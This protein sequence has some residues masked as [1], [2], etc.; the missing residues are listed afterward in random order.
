[1]TSYIYKLRI[2][3]IDHDEIYNSFHEEIID[4]D[5]IYNFLW[6]MIQYTR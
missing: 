2:K 5:E 4:H 1:M 6:L 3:V